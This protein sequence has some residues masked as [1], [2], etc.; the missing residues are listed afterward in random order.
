M[1]VKKLPP[2]KSVQLSFFTPEDWEVLQ[3]SDEIKRSVH[4][5]KK[6]GKRK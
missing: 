3:S 5:P 4:L 6:G 2:L 1:R